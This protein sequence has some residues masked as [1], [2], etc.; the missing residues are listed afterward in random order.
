MA[1]YNAGSSWDSSSLM[2]K[3]SPPRSTMD[4]WWQLP[5]LSSLTVASST[6]ASCYRVGAPPSKEQERAPCKI[7]QVRARFA[8]DNLANLAPTFFWQC[9]QMH[10]TMPGD[11]ALVTAAVKTEALSPT[12]AQLAGGAAAHRLLPPAAELVASLLPRTT[13]PVAPDP[14]CHP[15][16]GGC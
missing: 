13:G 4:S 2:H 6:R 12:H 3:P 11:H 8:W 10:T 14:S 5:T 1:H 15:H 9:I 16:C 7:S